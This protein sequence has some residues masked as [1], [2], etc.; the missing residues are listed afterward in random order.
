MESTG[1]VGQAKVLG[2]AARSVFGRM[3]WLRIVVAASAVA[4]FGLGSALTWLAQASQAPMRRPLST[5]KLTRFERL[6]AGYFGMNFDYVQTALASDHG[7]GMDARLAALQPG[8]LRYPGGTEANNFQ[9]LLGYP[10]KPSAH[11][12]CKTFICGKAN[13]VRG[14]RFTLAKLEAAYRATGAAPIFDLNMLDST[15]G[16]QLTMLRV[17]RRLGL[18][19]RYVELGNELYFGNPEWA[20]YYPTAAD[21]GRAVATY[22]KALHR[23]FHGVQVAAIGSAPSDTPRERTWNTQMLDAARRAHGLP[24]AITLHKYPGYRKSLQTTGLPALFAQPYAAVKDLNS[25][26][27]RLPVPEPAWVTEYNIEPKGESTGNPAELTYAHALFV[28]ELELLAPRIHG[29]RHVD[30]WTAFGAKALAAYDGGTTPGSSDGTVLSPAGLAVQWVDLAAHA[31]VATAQIAF[32]HPPTL[33]VNGPPALLGRAFFSSR[34]ERDVLLNL[35][36][37]PV[38]VRAGRA[39]AVGKPYHQATGNPTEAVS[40]A[41]QLPISSGTVGR[42]ITLP[43]DSITLI[44]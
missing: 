12:R 44:G 32:S 25:V 17:A 30:F 29:S 27:G 20:A 37:T 10:V 7:P 40:A 26:L 15:V 8:T 36:S 31:A 16:E 35:S 23:A 11:S 14:Y 38:T 19:V 2:R 28:A 43:P 9:W 18:P 42:T 39:V 22:V 6:P 41:S 1:V 5:A 13:V 21:Y 24:D 34:G 33:G 3:R 4:A